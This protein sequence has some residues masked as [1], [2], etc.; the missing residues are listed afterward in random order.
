MDTPSF[1]LAEKIIE[2]LVQEKL[3]TT[4][5]GKKMLPRLAEGKLRPE[6]WRLPIEIS[7]EKEA[8]P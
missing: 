4:Q 7:K 6:D 3:L 8:K 5:D 1:R 2:R